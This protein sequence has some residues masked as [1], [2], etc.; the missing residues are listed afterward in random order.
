MRERKKVS[1]EGKKWEPWAREM[2]I[3]PDGD[4]EH[5]LTVGGQTHGETQS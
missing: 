3:C 4:F 1:E 2:Q 5:L